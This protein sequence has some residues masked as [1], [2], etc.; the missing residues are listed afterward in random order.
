VISWQNKHKSQQNI[1]DTKMTKIKSKDIKKNELLLLRRYKWSLSIVWTLIILSTILWTYSLNNRKAKE[2]LLREARMVLNKDRALRLWA[3]SHGGVYVPQTEKNPP[4]QYLAHIPERDIVTPSGKK[5]T[6]MNPAYMLR[7]VHEAFSD[8]YGIKEHLTSLKLLN[9]NNKPDKWEVKALKSFE[10]GNKEFVGISELEEELHLR[11]MVPL[12]IVEGCLKCHKHQGYKI[13]N[14]RGGVS[15]SIPIATA[16]A[17]AYGEFSKEALSHIIVW[18]IGIAGIIIGGQ[19]LSLRILERQEAERTLRGIE[20]KYRTLIDSVKL[21]IAQIDKNYNIVMGNAALSKTL[22]KPI[23]KI[24]GTKCFE[25]FEKQNDVCKQCPGKV[26]MESKKP[27]EAEVGGVRSDGTHFIFLSRAFPTFNTNGE[28]TGFLEIG[29]DITKRKKTEELF[30][31]QAQIIEQVHDCVIITDMNGIIT[32]WNKGAYLLY[33]YTKQEA[34]GKH[35]SLLYYEK[36]YGVLEK[37]IIDPLIKQ[38]KH[39]LEARVKHKSG[40]EIF[41]NL[42]LSLVKDELR[43]TTNIVGYSIDITERKQAE[44]KIA[45]QS[46]EL[47]RSNTEL[48]QF[49]YIASHDLQEPLRMVGSYVKLLSNRYH[50]KMDSEADEFIAYIVDGVV[51]MHDLINDLL[52]Y[53]R[54][55]SRSKEFERIDC[56][57]VLEQALIDLQVVTKE[58][59][60]RIIYGFLPTIVGDGTQIRQLIE[61]LILNAIKF[62]SADNPTIDIQAEKEGNAWIFSVKDNGIGIKEQFFER[63]F[64]IFRRLHSREDYAGSGMG[65]AIC[66]RIV[67]RHGGRIWVESQDG[68]GS[69]FYFTIPNMQKVE[70]NE[71]E[72]I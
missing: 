34:L 9:S 37:K 33:G 39:A 63:I 28:V 38:G 16:M 68:A 64:S 7:K 54:V 49:A 4:N 36:D 50:G 30:K 13:G 61:N 12:F 23:N 57:T 46:K 58:N 43:N 52:N 15:V 24:I 31:Q 41:V 56:N 10:K 25:A 3:S 53:S 32:F 44:Q 2:I 59:K 21:V 48:E 51:R 35:I 60:A 67:E 14:V 17:E 72:I 66:K 55:T 27:H 65:L 70:Y 45:H 71:S 40:R 69:V 47:K 6:L 5:L 22:K 62:R 29:E 19:K 26:A 8:L 20:E 11:L 42:S 1:A 18:I